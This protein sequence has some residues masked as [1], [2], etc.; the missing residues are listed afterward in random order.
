[1]AQNGAARDGGLFSRVGKEGKPVGRQ[2][3]VIITAAVK[4]INFTTFAAFGSLAA[5]SK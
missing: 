2:K 1:M 4:R 5:G 3:L